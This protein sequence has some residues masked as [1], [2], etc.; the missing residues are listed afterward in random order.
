MVDFGTLPR[1][2]YPR[3]GRKPAQIGT[4]VDGGYFSSATSTKFVHR[5]DASSK[6]SD[7]NCQNRYPSPFC[8]PVP[9]RS[10]SAIPFGPPVSEHAHCTVDIVRRHGARLAEVTQFSFERTF[11]LEY[12]WDTTEIEQKDRKPCAVQSLSSRLSPSSDFRDVF[13]TIFSAVLQAPLSVRSLRMRPV[14]APSLARLL[15]VPLAQHVTSTLLSA[16]KRFA[17]GQ[18]VQINCRRCIY[19]LA[20]ILYS[21][22]QICSARS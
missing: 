6:S 4:L 9:S 21:R 5:S 20:A 11:S 12:S 3:I 17:C 2:V 18:N 16:V 22:N 7:C 1:M 8:R 19:A 15:V 13:R 14:V 10:R